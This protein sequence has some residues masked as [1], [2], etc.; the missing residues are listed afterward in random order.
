M[1]VYHGSSD[2]VEQPDVLHSYRPLD[3][4][5]GFYVTTNYEQAERWAKRKADLLHKEKAYVNIY[6]VLE[7]ESAFNVKTFSNDL[8]EWIDFVCR[9]R[10]GNT[11]YQAYDIIKG[12]VA[13][14]KV[15]RVVDLYHTGVWDKERALKEIKVY[16]GYDQIAFISQKAI[17]SLI[18]FQSI[19]EV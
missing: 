2:I 4:G 6:E 9:C 14:D 13:N 16:P 5:K 7:D 10:D 17:N 8:D 3:F 1:I 19:K 12:K 18:K 15:F 11:D